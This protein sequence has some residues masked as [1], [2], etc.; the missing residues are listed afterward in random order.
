MPSKT[1]VDSIRDTLRDEMARDERV[2]VMGEDVGRQGGVFLATEGLY[3]QFGADRVIDTPLAELSIVGIAIGAA[4]VGLRPVA[5]IQFADFIYP[6]FDQIVNEAAKMRYRTSG[7][8]TCPLV[9]RTPYGGGIHGGL[10][11]SQSIE[12]F[13][14]HVPGLKVIAPSTPYAAKGLLSAAIRDPD[15]IL[16][17]EHK[18]T[19]RA[20]K[21]EVPDEDYVL[22]I[23]KA[24]I[25]RAGS[26]V[27][28]VSYGAMLHETLAAA[29]QLARDDIEVEVIDLQT[30]QPLD[31]ET[32]LNSVRKTSKVCIVHEDTRM[33]GLG[34]E[35]AALISEE[36]FLDLDAPIRRV[37][38]PDLPGIPFNEA[39][40]QAFL[41]DADKIGKALRELAAF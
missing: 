14:C 27:T 33:M 41:P 39:G 30:L 3:Q 20:V 29:E 24:E 4:A 13:F 6:A 21:G 16:F 22:P 31:R 12:A 10:Y 32:I 40:E 2:I 36:A 26:D 28:A 23:G 7:A 25:V 34:A 11:H 35:I 15:P 18:K 37:T 19:Y 5:E 38:G 9:I 1:I 8:W 17:L